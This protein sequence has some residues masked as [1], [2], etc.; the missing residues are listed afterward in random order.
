M[1]LS[2]IT[3]TF[4]RRAM[5]VAAL[6][7]VAR[8]GWPDVEHIVVDGG[9]TDGTL[10]LV[11]SR[12][13]L[14]LIGGPDQ[15]IYDALNK[16][17]AAATGDAVGFLNSDD[18]YEPGAFAAAAEAFA[19]DPDSDA[20]CGAARL[21]ADGETIELYDNEVDKRLASART[22]LLGA[23]MIN[24]RF[25]RPSTLAKI[26][27]FSTNY[28]VV[29]DR[30]FLMRA[31]TLGIRSRPTDALIYTY[32][33]HH[34]SLSFSGEAAQR[35]AIWRELLSVSRHWAEAE[36][37]TA[38]NRRIARSLEGRCLGR[39]IQQDLAEGK[40]GDAWRLL[41][42]SGRSLPQNV[43][44]LASGLIDATAVRIAVRTALR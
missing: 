37:I 3:P 21:V 4:N 15:G 1:R 26:G 14:R 16:G 31:V 41:T 34:A 43:S 7:S 35:P 42:Q 5:L 13:N 30:D 9:S 10:D 6:D 2:I 33:R 8:Q 38:S 24:A 27:P 18:Y 22:A 29:S 23:C 11:G 36:T 12:P 32:Q 39:L 44:S 20:V 40:P 28:R 25:F 19:A 17:I